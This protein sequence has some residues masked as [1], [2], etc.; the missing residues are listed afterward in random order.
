MKFPLKRNV[1]IFKKI[2]FLFFYLIPITA[3]SQDGSLDTNFN[4]VLP[5]LT[6]SIK[7]FVTQS[8]GKTVIVGNFNSINGTSAG[9]IARLNLDGSLDTSF[10]VG[11][12]V[13]GSSPNRPY[14]ISSIAILPNDKIIIVGFFRNFNNVLK[15]SIVKLNSDGSI[16]QSFNTGNGF[17]ADDYFTN[18]IPG[19]IDK[20]VVKTN[21]EIITEGVFKEYNNQST[22]NITNNLCLLNSNGNLNT[23]LS[24]NGAVNGGI[25]A[26]EVQT[27]GKIILSTV[28]FTNFSGSLFPQ[29]DYYLKR[30]NSNGSLDNTF[31]LNN[32]IL[33]SA[34]IGGIP[35]NDSSEYVRV[36]DIK[37]LNN[38]K[39]IVAGSFVNKFGTNKRSISLLNSNGTNDNS[40]IGVGANTNGSSVDIRSIYIQSDGKILIGGRFSFFS[41]ISAKNIARVNQNGTYDSTFNSGNGFSGGSQ[42]NNYLYL[43]KQLSNNKAIC[44]GDFTSYNGI[45]RNSILRLNSNLIANNDYGVSISGVNNVVVSNVR[46][47]DTYNGVTAT[48]SNTI[49]SLISSTNSGITLDTATGSVIV[50]ST[51]PAGTYTLTYQI[52]AISN[53]TNCATATVTI[54]VNAQV[55]NAN[56][57]DFTST[58]ISYVNG[59]TTSSVT[60][61]DT[62]NGIAVNNSDITI[63]LVNNGG[64][65]GATINGSGI[66]T[67]PVSTSVGSY[68]LTYQ[69]CQNSS[70]TNCDQASVIINVNE[71]VIMTPDLVF[72]IRANSYVKHALI[73]SDGKIII[74]GAFTTYNNISTYR[75]AR[76]NTDLT[77]DQ[78][79]NTSG[80]ITQ[81]QD[82][83]KIQPDNKIIVVGAF[84][85]FNGG[86][87]GKGLARLNTDGSI[88]NN[89]NVGGQGVNTLSK[90]R[91]RSCAIQTD[92]KIL[93]G[94]GYIKTYNDEAVT[95]MIRINADGTLDETFVFPYTSDQFGNNLYAPVYQIVVQPDGK[96]LVSGVTNNLPNSQ[97][98]FFRLMPNGSIDST[99][100]IGNT[101]ADVFSTNCTS[102]L[103]PI[104]SV[105]LQQDGKIL[106]VGSFNSYNNNTNYKN[107]VRLLSNGE[108]DTSFNGI[109][110]STDRVI[111]DIS[112]DSTTGKMIIGGEFTTFNG[113]SVNKI[114]RLNQNGSLD[115]TFNS[116]TGTAHTNTS[117]F[118]YNNI[119]VIKKQGDGKVILGGHFTSY[120]GISA[121]NITRIQPS[122]AGGQAK[123]IELY[124][125]EPEIDINGF[126]SDIKVYPNPSSDILNIDLTNNYEEFD[127]IEIFNLLG[128]LVYKQKLNIKS[129]NGL[130]LSNVQS[131]YYI[132]RIFNNKNSKQVK[133]IKK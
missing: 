106:L 59:G 21:G 43:I 69:I 114:I 25:N 68:T 104:Q 5:S 94:G 61:N 132:A 125:S 11:N 60:T 121:L 48:S 36:N 131:G 31:T 52:C 133:L 75:I 41:N 124:E 42:S 32:T 79:Y 100:T 55:I 115:T 97:P 71:P 49:L 96:I 38:G 113:N 112:Y 53:P 83:M 67:V 37:Y 119:H 93:L 14:Y 62:L 102:C 30:I 39:I 77:L 99:F 9:C 47:N 16:D 12:G 107:I 80:P 13:I 130:N 103:S 90:D 58:P 29:E 66:I 81:M 15:N 129:I 33:S 86:S 128:E 35:F 26:F 19:I 28:K 89:F 101:G 108:I 120:N 109:G 24:Y 74:G 92:G 84:S 65:A 54:T 111:K 4:F 18:N 78:I 1:S 64:L 20:I 85:G 6:G 40:F 27:D 73:Q 7:D 110:S 123:G 23:S 116:G 50:A 105:V 34:N 10:N 126:I 3:F 82:D 51:V 45:S 91:I 63:T 122:V 127:N 70:P 56:N 44:I 117:S 118:V 87:N 57:D 46:S 88:D 98:N 2:I 8:D 17:L 76:L 22:I 72:G 95:N